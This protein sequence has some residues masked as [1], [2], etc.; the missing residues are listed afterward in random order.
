MPRNCANSYGNGNVVP[1]PRLHKVRQLM[2]KR[3]FKSLIARIAIVALALSLIVPFVPAAFAQD[4]ANTIPYAENGTDVVQTFTLSDQD[5][6][7][8]EWSVSGDDAG[9]FEISSDGALSFKS[10]PNYERSC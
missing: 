6:S 8:G 9:D 10:S 5:D 4:G 3:P 7:G 1:V 2:L